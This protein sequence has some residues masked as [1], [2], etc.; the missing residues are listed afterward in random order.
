LLPDY[1]VVRNKWQAEGVSPEEFVSVEMAEHIKTGHFNPYR[2]NALAKEEYYLQLQPSLGRTI[3]FFS[4]V[5]KQNGA[6]PVVVYIPSRHQVSDHYLQFE[7]E[8]CTQC[9]NS[10][11]LTTPTYQ[12]HQQTLAKQ[13]EAQAIPFIDLS[14]TIR[15]QEAAGNHLY[16]YYDE[17]MRGRGY[18]LVGSSIWEQ[19]Q[20]G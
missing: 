9:P 8:T 20:N 14:A 4:E 13:C 2:M 5:C 7:K 11:D 12:V 16:W 19:W 17:H 15:A 1:N 18:T 10:I 3:S 6:M